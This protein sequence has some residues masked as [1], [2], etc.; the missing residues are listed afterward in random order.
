MCLGFHGT[1][2]TMQFHC[3]QFSMKEVVVIFLAISQVKL[4]IFI[5]LWCD[6]TF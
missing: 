3:V 1:E 2:L 6:L 4:C 5:L